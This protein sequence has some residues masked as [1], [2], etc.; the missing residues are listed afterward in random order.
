MEGKRNERHKMRRLRECRYVW[1]DGWREMA[2]W[3]AALA[4]SIP[5]AAASASLLLLLLFSH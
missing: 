5:P 3:D 2:C 1:S 4:S